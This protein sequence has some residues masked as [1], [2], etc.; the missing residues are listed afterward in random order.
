MDGWTGDGGAPEPPDAMSQNPG[1]TAHTVYSR[2]DVGGTA[3][4]ADTA[5]TATIQQRYSNDTAAIQ[6]I[7]RSAADTTDTAAD[8]VVTVQIQQSTTVVPSAHFHN[9]GGVGCSRSSVVLDYN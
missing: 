4:T 7:L 3:D 9:L 2:T 8:S 1:D 5:D 6:Q